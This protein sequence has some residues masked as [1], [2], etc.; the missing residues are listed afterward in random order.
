M[1]EAGP[2]VRMRRF[3]D[4]RA[5]ENALW[6]VDSRLEYGNPDEDAFWAAGEDVL[7][8]LHELL[9]VQVGSTDV[10]IDVGCGI[11]RITRAL[12]RRAARVV[13]LDIS[14]EMLR[15]AREANPGLDNVD[16]VRGDGVSLAGVEDGIANAVISQVVFQH[17][18]DAAI[19]LGYV[20]EMGRVLRPGGWAAFQVS[21]DPSVHRP[22]TPLGHRLL[23][24]AGR[25]PRGQRDPAWLG[26][27]VDLD[28]LRAAASDGGLA[29]EQIRGEGTQFCQVL[30]RAAPG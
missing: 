22:R 14:D 25:A 13:A 6:F 18:P 1:R 9:G 10:V 16:W 27:A 23:A 4:E 28:D 11:G 20:R 7:D 17:I 3:W 26:S 2:G 29:V 30:L 21:N 5:R 12:A 24:L 19:T 15:R 8:K